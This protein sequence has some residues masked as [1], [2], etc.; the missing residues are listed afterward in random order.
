MDAHT[1]DKLEFDAVRRALA[2]HCSCAL[3]RELAARIQPSTEVKQVRLWLGQVAEMIAASA[4][5]QPGFPPLAG[6]H[7][8]RAHLGAAA[9][10]AGL[11]AEALAVVAETLGATGPLRSWVEAVGPQAPRLARLGER[12]G[13]FSVLAATISAAVDPRGRLRDEASPKLASIRRT[14]DRARDEISAVT[15]RL[16]KQPRVLRMLQYANATFHNDRLVLP[17]RAEHRGRVPGIVH[18]SS[19]SGATL[20]VEPAECVELNNS[21]VRLRDQERKEIGR[22]LGALTALVRDNTPE[23]LRTLAAITI[24]DLIAA[25]ARYGL[26][27]DCLCPEI[28]DDQIMYLYQAR[29]PV[30]LDLM[31]GNGSPSPGSDADEQ[32]RSVVPID[33]RLGDD[34]DLLVITGPNTG[35]KTVALKTIGLMVVMAQS[36]IPIPVAPGTEL[37][38]FRDVFIDVGDE[39][40][41]QQSLSTFS[42]H[43]SNILSVLKRCGPGSL[44][45]FDEVGAGTDPDEGAAI[46]RALIDELL[47]VGA[48]AVVSTHLSALKSIAFTHPRTDNAAVEFD[49]ATCRPTYRLLLG[50]PGNSNALIVAERLGMPQR[51]IQAARGY[52]D[53]RHRQLQQAI[54]GTLETRRQAE[55][56]R[57]AALAAKLEADRSRD[58]YEHQ[59]R[60][61]S[62]EQSRYRD[63]V[64]WINELDRGDPVYVR[65][66]ETE[67]R[68]V[69]MH[70]HKQCALVNVGALDFEVPLTDLAKPGDTQGTAR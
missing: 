26:Q 11:E 63:W 66:F 10:P 25:K 46:G 19:D 48:K 6:V 55:S 54:D 4:D 42:A 57:R 43:M 44:V 32:P 38:V 21:I 23:I 15:A 30:L 22:I 50:E 49:T 68:V 31:S 20:F 39:Q 17:L 51:L 16:L 7:D 37:P 34:F 13:D 18:R 12:I 14:I 33:V 64:S 62:A 45:L 52:L 40:S 2:A 65:S 47:R 67:A 29:H 53:D 1:L 27:R 69:R 60:E 28:R 70:L 36:G 9:T 61:L 5:G 24:L 58:D 8:L 41:L 59:R 56:A 35:G 3:G